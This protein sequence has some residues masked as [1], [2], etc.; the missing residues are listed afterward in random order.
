MFR[1]CILCDK[2]LKCMKQ[3]INY[4]KYKNGFVIKLCDFCKNNMKIYEK[5]KR[6]SMLFSIDADMIRKIY[7]QEI[8]K[9]L[10]LI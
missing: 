6:E 5:K 1:V 8:E 3:K 9:C 7:K 4:K 2:K 10:N